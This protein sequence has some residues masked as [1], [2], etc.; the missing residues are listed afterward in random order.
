MP[1]SVAVD[2]Q[3]AQESWE[4]NALKNAPPAFKLPKRNYGRPT[5]PPKPAQYDP[6]RHA[7]TDDEFAKVLEKHWKQDGTNRIVAS[8]RAY[9]WLIEA[10][11][12]ADEATESTWGP[13]LNHSVIMRRSKDE[14]FGW[15]LCVGGHA[16]LNKGELLPACIGE[17]E[18]LYRRA[19]VESDRWKLTFWLHLELAREIFD[20]LVKKHLIWWHNGVWHI[21]VDVTGPVIRRRKKPRVRTAKRR[22]A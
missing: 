12:R 4:Q 22:A 6:V 16:T 1:A 18:K 8:R 3:E 13:N 5:P 21:S 9:D 10:F 17:V 7:Q 2:P 11:L 14:L 15:L 19:L 20:E